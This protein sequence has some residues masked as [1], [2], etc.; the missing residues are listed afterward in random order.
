[1]SNLRNPDWKIIH[2]NET[3]QRKQFWSKK[4]S[5][6]ETEEYVKTLLFRDETI[7]MKEERETIKKEYSETTTNKKLLKSK[8]NIKTSNIYIN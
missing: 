8:N 2:R 7:C 1:M 5:V 4:I 3:K 6:Q